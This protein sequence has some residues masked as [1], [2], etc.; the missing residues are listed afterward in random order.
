VQKRQVRIV[1]VNERLAGAHSL[2]SE[3]GGAS[4]ERKVKELTK[5]HL[6]TRDQREG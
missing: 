4:Y 5:G 2:K 6:H 1:K 3:K